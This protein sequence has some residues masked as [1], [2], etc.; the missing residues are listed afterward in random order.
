MNL[1]DIILAS[2]SP[3]R[4]QLL[5]RLE[6]PFSAQSPDMEE[7]RIEGESAS[8]TVQRLALEKARAVAEIQPSGLII[9]SDQCAV[10]GSSILGKPGNEEQAFK[11]LRASSG[12]NVVFHT[13]LCLLNAETGHY[14]LDDVLYQV[15]FRTLSDQQI[16]HYLQREQ[17]FNCAGSFKSEALGI[18]LF[19]AMEGEDPTALIG[20]PLI[21][22]TSM[23]AVEG[24][25]LPLSPQY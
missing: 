5:E 4:H 12:Q 25:A 3:F 6:I 7:A 24:I 9:G 8:D 19:E 1:P 15:R 18:T 14:Q 11:Q 16:R 10:L 21:R 2:T 13:G 23:L 17:P 20:L 22:L